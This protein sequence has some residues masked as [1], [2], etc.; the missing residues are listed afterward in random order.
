MSRRWISLTVFVLDTWWLVSALGISYALRYS[1]VRVHSSASYGMLVFAGLGV[2]ALLF[3]AMRLDGFDGGWRIATIVGRTAFATGLLMAFVLTAAYLDKL[4]YSR[5][6][7]SYFG[8]LLF[9]GFLLIRVGVYSFLRGQ[10][11]RGVTRKVVVV[12]ND[13][14]AREFAFKIQRHPELLYELVGTLYPVGDNVSNEGPDLHPNKAL[15]SM[16]VL[17]TL[18]GHGIDELIVLEQPPDLEF[19]TFINRCRNQGIHVSVLPR[20]Y[21]LYTS[22]LKLMEIDGL[23]LISLEN[24]AKFPLATSVKRAA[25]LVIAMLLLTPGA[26]IVGTAMLVLTLDRRKPLRRE[27]RVGKNGRQFGMY[28]LN[29]DRESNGGPRYEQ[30]LRDLSISELPQ[31]LNV[32]RGEMSLVGPRPESPERVR[33]YSEWQRERLKALPGMT[34]LAQVN[35]LREQHPSEEKTRF[36]LQYIL[37]WSPLEDWSLLLQTIG[38]LMARCFRPGRRAPVL[39]MRSSIHHDPVRFTGTESVRG[40]A[41]ADRA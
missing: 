3:R 28:R 5:L 13:R 17:E 38:T 14:V 32:L 34:G 21:E 26:I 35:G 27:I 18:A 12:G 10:Y 4:Y 23:P 2:W 41:R 19:Q 25:D 16:D 8:L 6:L 24:P 37:E 36:D 7:L 9:V 39:P 11:R 1:Q 33:N 20:G 22:K 15:S 29:I 31:L 30:T 40:V